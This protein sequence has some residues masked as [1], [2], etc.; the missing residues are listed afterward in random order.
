MPFKSINVL[1]LIENKFIIFVYSNNDNNND[2]YNECK[3]VI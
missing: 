1:I 3:P 2:N